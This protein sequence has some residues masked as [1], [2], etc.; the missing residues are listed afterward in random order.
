MLQATHE[1]CAGFGARL[2]ESLPAHIVT[3]RRLPLPPPADLFAICRRGDRAPRLLGWRLDDPRTPVALPPTWH[4]RPRLCG[5]CAAAGRTL[6][7]AVALW[8]LGRSQYDTASAMRRTG[9]SAPAIRTNGQSGRVARA[10]VQRRR[11]RVP[12]LCDTTRA[13]GPGQSG[14]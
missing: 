1:C 2:G 7:S 4:I 11:N 5:N 14:N 8:P 10:G 13:P 6:V 3:T 12:Q 9:S